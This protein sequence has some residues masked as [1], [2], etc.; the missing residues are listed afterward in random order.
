MAS[1][2]TSPVSSNSS[3]N[4]DSSP[5][6]D[7]A[8]S[9]TDTSVVNKGVARKWVYSMSGVEEKVAELASQ[10]ESFELKRDP[11]R[12]EILWLIQMQEK[13]EELKDSF[14]KAKSTEKIH[15]DFS[16]RVLRLYERV[17]GDDFEDEI[18]EL[19]ESKGLLKKKVRAKVILCI[20]KLLANFK[21]EIDSFVPEDDDERFDTMMDNSCAQEKYQDEIIYDL[22]VINFDVDLRARK[23]NLVGKLENDKFFAEVKRRWGFEEPE[24]YFNYHGGV[25]ARPVFHEE[26]I[27]LSA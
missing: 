27:G 17:T 24:K 9:E 15:R 22:K 20:E 2:V 12:K 7:A 26:S 3:C 5:N 18:E 6:S 23:F 1:S 21:K 19:E 8:D 25:K 16:I 11:K 13:F 14:I 10:F 4:I